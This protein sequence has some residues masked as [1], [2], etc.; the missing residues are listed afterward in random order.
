MVKVVPRSPN[1]LPLRALHLVHV[2]WKEK[3]DA[4]AMRGQQED[5]VLPRN[6]WHL[7]GNQKWQVVDKLMSWVFFM[8]FL[9]TSLPSNS[10]LFVLVFV[11][12]LCFVGWGHLMVGSHMTIIPSSDFPL[13]TKGRMMGVSPGVQDSSP[14]IRRP[15]LSKCKIVKPRSGRV[16]DCSR[17]C[18]LPL[19]PVP[20]WFEKELKNCQTL[21]TNRLWMA[22][23]K[24]CKRGMPF[25]SA[26]KP[27]EYD[28][29]DLPEASLCYWHDSRHT[30]NSPCILEEIKFSQGWWPSKICWTGIPSEQQFNFRTLGDGQRS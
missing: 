29:F 24:H 2:P 30:S 17:I 5:V 20:S 28:Q 16:N 27:K 7:N 9:F 21:Q 3:H 15:L 18:L 25:F 26:L 23:P 10:R 11:G 12:V 22:P 1:L 6:A 13:K 4:V 19:D 14:P 8:G